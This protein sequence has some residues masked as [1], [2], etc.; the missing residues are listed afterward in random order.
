MKSIALFSALCIILIAC[1]TNS[2]DSGTLLIKGVNDFS[3]SKKT[4]ITALQTRNSNQN[5]YLMYNVSIKVDIAEVW[6]S[7]ELVSEGLKDD[8][9][10]YKVG[11]SS[12]LKTVDQFE[13]KADDLPVGEYKSVKILFRNKVVRIAAYT[14]DINNKVEMLSSL[15]EGGQG[16]ESLI[17][18]YFSKRG[19]H[20]INEN[21]IFNCNSMGESIRAFTITEGKITTILWM[22]GSPEMKPTDCTFVWHD[23]NGNRSWDAG[24]DY[25]DNFQCTI[26]APMWSFSVDDGFVDPYIK[27]ALTDIDGNKYDAV[28]I[29]NQIW[30]TEN[31]RTTKLNNGQY[32]M[33]WEENLKYRQIHA[34][35]SK[36][37]VDTTVRSYYNNDSSYIE[38]FG[39]MYSRLSVATDNLCPSGWHIPSREDWDELVKY[40]GNNA[41]GKL[42]ARGNDIWYG[43]NTQ[44]SDEY[45]FCALPGGMLTI[46][47]SFSEDGKYVSF[48]TRCFL[49]ARFR[50]MPHLTIPPIEVAMLSNEN[51]EIVFNQIT[52]DSHAYVR[53]IKDR[54]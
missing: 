18:N 31:L 38:K 1:D 24:E 29:G 36:A 43:Q 27:N 3:S 51:G 15:S 13:F 49:W 41:G 46:N 5:E 4:Q 35:I 10:W 45:D 12:G 21:G 44:A 20:S 7:Q 33:T 42:K 28:K 47:N 53:C 9:K 14:T 16:D 6:V 11:E 50:P 52:N 23:V 48:G 25:V 17:V 37:P 32:L 39:Y 19:N 54:N 30:M 26:D 8:F 34:D 40:L 2:G 22:S